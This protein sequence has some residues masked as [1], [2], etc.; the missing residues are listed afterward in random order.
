MPKDNNFL[1]CILP[2]ITNGAETWTLTVEL[3]HQFKVAQRAM[4]RAILKVS[5]ADRIR[6]EAIRQ[7]TEVTDVAR[8]I[9]TLKWNTT[10][11]VSRHTDGRW[12]RFVLDW[13]PRLGKHSV[14][15]PAA[16][17]TGDLKKVAGIEWMREA[18][19]Q[20]SWRSMWGAYDQQ[21]TA[22]G[23][24]RKQFEITILILIL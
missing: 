8:R 23:W 22:I 21:W 4:K 20:D 1:Q 16:R 17:W 9:S 15:C 6:N 2:V 18:Q 24:L 7:R 5:L 19:D 13:R 11:H 10:G 14:G 12:S 3:V